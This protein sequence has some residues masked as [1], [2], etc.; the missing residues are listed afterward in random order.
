MLNG[1][2]KV[3]K[4]GNVDISEI[5]LFVFRQQGYFLNYLRHAEISLVYFPTNAIYFIILTH[6]SC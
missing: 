1:N 3:S 4:T 6:P 5:H 2:E